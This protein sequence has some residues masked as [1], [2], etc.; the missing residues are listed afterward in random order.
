QSSSSSPS[1]P[2]CLAAPTSPVQLPALHGAPTSLVRPS[3]FGLATLRS[4]DLLPAALIQPTRLVSYGLTTLEMAGLGFDVELA[5]LRRV[6]P[7]ISATVAF[8]LIRWQVSP[9]F[10]C[11]L[12]MSLAPSRCKL[13]T[14]HP[15][16]GRAACRE[17]VE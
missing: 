8:S 4:L 16:I 2:D 13:R 14:W 11:T 1:S 6:G 3:F 10:F 15:K 9:W 12:S 5:A 7:R 17:R